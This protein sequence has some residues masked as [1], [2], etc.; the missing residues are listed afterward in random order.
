MDLYP[1]IVKQGIRN[2]ADDQNAPEKLIQWLKSYGSPALVTWCF[3]NRQKLPS[4]IEDVWAWET[5]DDHLE[6]HAQSRLEL[7]LR[8]A[9]GSCGC[10]GRWAQ[11]A[12]VLLQKNGV[13]VN[14]FCSMV[15]RL[16]Q[17][18]RRE[19]TPVLV[20]MGKF[21]GEGKSYLYSPFKH[22]FGEENVQPTPQPGNF[23]LL[24]LERKKVVLLDEWAFDSAVLP[25]ATQLL[26]YE[27]KAF[28]ITRPQNKEY[29]GHLLYSGTAPIFA[30]CK[31][32]DL[33]PIMAKAQQAMARGYASEHTMLM[34]RLLVISFSCP[35]KP[36][37]PKIYECPC[38]FAR[39]LLQFGGQ[40]P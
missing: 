22:V 36:P 5:V 2:T 26:W 9:R 39:M 14:W 4:I 35:F 19:D 30:T 25:L 31:E 24:G 6:T 13:N 12:L 27:G 7:L 33:G 38:C 20:L 29:S 18:G 37:E 10:G 40:N 34:R 21:G 32:K 23:P 16:L 15:L 8:A 1:I 28:P 17:N 11:T 3:K